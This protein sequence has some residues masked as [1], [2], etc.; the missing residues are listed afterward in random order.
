MS[1]PGREQELLEMLD[2]INGAGLPYVLVG[3]WAVTAF[4]QR[5]TDV[6]DIPNTP[7]HVKPS[8]SLPYY[9]S[10]II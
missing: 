2:A 4:N 9:H 3:G 1:L 7:K 5:L 6:V 10:I 8:D